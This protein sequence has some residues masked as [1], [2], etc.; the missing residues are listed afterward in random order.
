MAA[1]VTNTRAA[2]DESYLTSSMEDRG[3]R[4][5]PSVTEKFLAADGS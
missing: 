2:Q 5:A 4:R 3:A 1:M